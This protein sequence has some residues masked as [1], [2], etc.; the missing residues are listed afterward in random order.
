[1]RVIKK[2]RN[3]LYWNGYKNF[4]CFCFIG[5][6]GI[7]NYQTFW[8][9]LENNKDLNNGELQVSNGLD[10]LR[11]KNIYCKNF[12]WFDTGNADAMFD[13][14]MFVKSIQSRTGQMI[15][16]IEEAAYKKGLIS[17]EQFHELVRELPL[18]QYKRYLRDKH[19]VLQYT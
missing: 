6:A 1:M 17:E 11:G 19:Q 13:A 18:S 2:S 5:L 15:G 7:N 3:F 14:A 9:S 12:T 10:G 8:K 16:C 4:N